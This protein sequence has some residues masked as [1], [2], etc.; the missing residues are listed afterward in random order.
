MKSIS[1]VPSTADESGVPDDDAPRSHAQ[2][3]YATLRGEILRGGLMA[4]E[5][6]RA[7]DLRRRYNLSLTP[8]REALT[9]LA[10]EGL[11]AAEA[12]RGMRV[13]EAS[14]EDFSDLM[15]TRR[16]IERIC[17]AR[18][19]ARGDADWEAEIVAA[20]HLLSRAKLP[21]SAVDTAAMATWEARHRRF[22]AAL[23][24]ACDS[25][26]LLRIWN[27]LTDHSERYRKLRMLRPP[28][29]R[30]KARNVADEHAAIAEAVL[31]RNRTRAQALMDAHL[32]ATERAVAR[33]LE[34]A[35]AS[36]KRRA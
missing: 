3:A 35:P 10:S 26:W 22:H 6:L 20:L 11:V 24:A 27:T 18:A 29:A 34:P 33:H 12:H 7:A 31:K 14:L 8:I 2:R 19:I 9:R 30:P 16:E 5:R 15:A 32:A 1:A 4:G 21:G 13:A 36:R 25:L 28:A 23:V 17:L